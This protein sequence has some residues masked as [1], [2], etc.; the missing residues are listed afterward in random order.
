[1]MIRILVVEDHAP[2]VVLVEAL[3]NA[4]VSAV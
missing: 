4:D 1:M 2:D 3:A